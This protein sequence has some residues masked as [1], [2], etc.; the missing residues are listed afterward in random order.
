M[1]YLFH[2]VPLL[3]FSILCFYFS[4]ALLAICSLHFFLFSCI[5]SC[6]LLLLCGYNV[7]CECTDRWLFHTLILLQ[8][9]NHTNRKQMHQICF[10][11]RKFLTLTIITSVIAVVVTQFNCKALSHSYTKS[12]NLLKVISIDSHHLLPVILFLTNT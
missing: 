8:V 1:L 4:S 12:V 2:S 3:F 5:T 6:I 11:H 7:Y 10:S 9:P